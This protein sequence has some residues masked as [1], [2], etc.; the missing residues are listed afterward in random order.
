MA[1]RIAIHLLEGLAAGLVVATIC[2]AGIV[3]GDVMGI[4]RLIQTVQGGTMALY[5]LWLG[6]IAVFAP[7]SMA[8]SFAAAEIR[9]DRRR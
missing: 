6:L 2:T 3:W 1:H 8:V 7:A 5:V 4:G 9:E